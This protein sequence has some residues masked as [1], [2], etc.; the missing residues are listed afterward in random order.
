MSPIDDAELGRQVLAE[1]DAGRPSSRRR[2]AERR[3]GLPLRIAPAIS[4]TCCSSAGSMPLIWTAALIAAGVDQRLAENRRRGA[5]DVRHLAQRRRLGAIVG[6]AAA[7]PDVD[8]RIGRRGSGR[9][10]PAAGRSS[11]RAR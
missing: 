5:D 2:V 10:A 7:L 3:R 4:V 8:V 9:G 6:D 1:Q 11:A